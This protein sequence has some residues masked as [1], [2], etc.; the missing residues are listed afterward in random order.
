[1]SSTST[2]TQLT[3][4]I[5]CSTLSLPLWCWLCHRQR[6]MQLGICLLMAAGILQEALQTHNLLLLLLHSYKAHC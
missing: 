6:S 5:S 2:L 3:S 1:M 4:L